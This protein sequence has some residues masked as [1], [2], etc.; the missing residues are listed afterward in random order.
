MSTFNEKFEIYRC[1]D[2][3]CWPS[4]QTIWEG[5]GV[6]S[7]A[8]DVSYLHLN[9]VTLI[10][11]TLWVFKLRLGKGKESYSNKYSDYWISFR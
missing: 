10:S 11:R 3:I 8:K 6:L 5:I 2:T 7:I 4:Y 1:K 9:T